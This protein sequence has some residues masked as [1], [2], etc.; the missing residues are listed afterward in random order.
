MSD[1]EQLA[2]VE[3]EAMVE[4]RNG[5]AHGGFYWPRAMTLWRA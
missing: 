2:D 1:T 5:I 4:F 3:V